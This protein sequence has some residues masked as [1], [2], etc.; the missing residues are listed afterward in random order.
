[1]NDKFLIL[2]AV[3]VAVVILVLAFASPLIGGDRRSRRLLRAR[4][5]TL[6]QKT[7]VGE[8][9][10]LA[11]FSYLDRLSSR[12]R[13]LEGQPALKPLIRLLQQAGIVIPAYRLLAGSLGGDAQGA[14]DY[15]D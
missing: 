6:T 15:A 10:P 8:Q 11:R 13:W 2:I 7:Q 9:L 14:R 12:E 5:D 1:M 4:I 3:F